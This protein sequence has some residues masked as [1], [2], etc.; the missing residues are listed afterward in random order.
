MTDPR[1]ITPELLS[2]YELSLTVGRSLEPREACRE[3]LRALVTQRNLSAASLWWPDDDCSGL[4]LL[5]ALPRQ[6]VSGDRL[7]ESHPLA[8]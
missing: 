6:S 3:F 4:R 2:L 1:D 7:P 5:D 8:E